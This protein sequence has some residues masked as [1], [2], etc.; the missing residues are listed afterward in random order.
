MLGVL[1]MDITTCISTYLDM[2]PKIFPEE[3]FIAGSKISRLF[4]GI[5]GSARFDAANLETV[6]KAMVA[7]RFGQEEALL[8]E[9]DIADQVP[10]ACQTYDGRFLYTLQHIRIWRKY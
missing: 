3:G 10:A 9:A 4:K 1:G 7:D 2:A 5:K 8:F 6:V